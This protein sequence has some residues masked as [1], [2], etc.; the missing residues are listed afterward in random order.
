MIFFIIKRTLIAIPT[1]FMIILLVFLLVHLAPGNPF[2]SEKA[3]TP[4][5]MQQLMHQ[6]RLDLPLYKQFLL[7][8]NDLLHG[9]LG[10]SYKFIGQSINKLIFPD[11]LGGFWVT[12]RLGFYTM[13]ITVPVGIIIGIYAGVKKDSWFD[14]I[15]ITS[16]MLFNSI[17]VIITGPIMVLIFSVTLKLLPASGFGDGDFMHLLLPVT[18][19]SIAYLPTIAF[20]TRASIIEV[21]NS[22]F[23][24][25][26][27]SRGIP[28]RKIIFKHAIKPTM[29]PVVSLLGP[30]FAGVLIGAIVTEQVFALPGLG[31]LTTN[32]ATNRDYNMIMAIT[33]FGS[34]LT[35]MFNVLVD[36]I[37]FYLDPRITQ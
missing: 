37:Y 1:L 17:P 33:I 23:I 3:L 28:Q 34:F 10:Y 19:L 25:S 21:L 13:L 2:E 4:A 36:I 9:N 12:L 29:L 8:L 5:V 6:Y 18:V 31:I 20:I 26:A 22:N 35:I 30:M 15:I 7:Y 24:R 27:R 32:A 16:N 11:N 14:R